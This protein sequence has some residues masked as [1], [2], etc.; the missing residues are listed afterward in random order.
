MNTKLLL[1]KILIGFSICFLV[2]CGGGGGGGETTS[3][4]VIT[5]T[6]GDG[7]ADSSDAF[8]DDESET[9]DADSDG[10][11]DNADNFAEVAN[12]DQAD[13]DVNGSGAA[14]STVAKTI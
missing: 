14:D 11:G 9:S 1:S 5:D 4:P 10:V 2:A 13:A 6:D 3:E 8:P 12:A 7:V